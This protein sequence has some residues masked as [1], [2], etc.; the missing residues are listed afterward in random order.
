VVNWFRR[1][2]KEVPFAVRGTLEIGTP[3]ARSPVTDA[4][5]AGGYLTIVNTGTEADRLVA[6]SSPLADSVEIHG[7]KVVGPNIKMKPMANGLGI[8]AAHTTTL[9]PRGYHLL[10]Q[11]LKAP[12]SAGARLPVTLTFEK[13]GEIAVAL[14]VAEPGPVGDAILH[15]GA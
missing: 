6:A 7:I 2:R 1:N 3:W 11:G 5:L 8:P 4:A 12:L 15:E 9:K 13:A 10:V 14:T